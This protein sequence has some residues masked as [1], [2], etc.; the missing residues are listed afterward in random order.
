MVRLFKNSLGTYTW[1]EV[2][3]II[4]HLLV[5]GRDAELETVLKTPNLGKQRD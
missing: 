4:G 2:E 3:Q 5:N 1:Y